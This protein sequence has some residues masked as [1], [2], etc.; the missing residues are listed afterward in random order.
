MKNSVTKLVGV[1]CGAALLWRP[2]GFAPPLEGQHQSYGGPL[3]K[4]N[5]GGSIPPLHTILVGAGWPGC[6]FA[7]ASFGFSTH[8]HSRS[9]PITPRPTPSNLATSATL[10]R[11]RPSRSNESLSRPRKN[12][13]FANTLLPFP[14]FRPRLTEPARPFLFQPQCTASTP[15]R[16]ACLGV[17]LSLPCRP[18]PL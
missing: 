14:M 7:P 15:T 16:S 5:A 18:Y 6:R 17:W 11:I 13:Q 3:P 8:F 9:K 10:V 2:G 12:L 4:S 1:W